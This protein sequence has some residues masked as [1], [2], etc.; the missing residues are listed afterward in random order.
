MP[1]LAAKEDQSIWT[2]GIVPCKGLDCNACDAFKLVSKGLNLLWSGAALVGAAM[3][4]YGGFLYF[5]NKPAEAKKVL[6]NTVIGIAL[7]FLAWIGIDTI[8]KL[9]VSQKFSGGAAE[10]LKSQEGGVVNYGP[11][12]D[13][14]CQ[15][16]TTKGKSAEEKL[17]EPGT[18]LDLGLSVPED[19]EDQASE[20]GSC[21]YTSVLDE[22]INRDS[23]KARGVYV[24]KKACPLCVRYQDVAGG[25]TSVDRLKS[26][27]IEKLG[28]IA[29]DCCPAI[30]L[31]G[32]TE[33][34]HVAHGPFKPVVDLNFTDLTANT[35]KKAID[36]AVKAGK[37]PEDNKY[38]IIKIC[39]TPQDAKYRLNCNYPEQVRHLHVVFKE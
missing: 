21:P 3:L 34:G 23:L 36:E 15:A 13:I 2:E 12:N 37:K 4:M 16:V 30:Y 32:G 39:T 5:V 8:I 19:E 10:V 29:K 9:L 22:G 31:T 1:A 6:T 7:A 20:S 33:Y 26:G 35:I 38:G 28:M 17:G 14:T 11:W 27:V 24:M 18:K 25:C